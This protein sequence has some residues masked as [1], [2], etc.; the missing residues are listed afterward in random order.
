MTKQLLIKRLIDITIL[1]GQVYLR[2]A[3]SLAIARVAVIVQMLQGQV[4]HV[5]HNVIFFIRFSAIVFGTLLLSAKYDI[6]KE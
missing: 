4:N 2:T 1:Q 6:S 3:V 5:I